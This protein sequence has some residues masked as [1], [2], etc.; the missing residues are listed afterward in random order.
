M[1]GLENSIA[2]KTVQRCTVLLKPQMAQQTY[3]QGVVRSFC[4]YP[5]YPQ[6]IA[7]GSDI[8]AISRPYYGFS[9]LLQSAA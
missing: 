9:A 7:H 3:Y 2:Y 1:H 4:F 5:H 8:A 6:L